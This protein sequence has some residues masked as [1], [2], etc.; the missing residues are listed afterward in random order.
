MFWSPLPF[1]R[2]KCHDSFF[3]FTGELRLAG[4][5]NAS[6]SPN[7]AVFGRLCKE[8]GGSYHRE[9]KTSKIALFLACR[10]DFCKCESDVGKRGLIG[11]RFKAGLASNRELF[12]GVGSSI[13]FRYVG[14]FKQVVY[15][16]IEVV[17]SYFFLTVQCFPLLCKTF[18]QMLILL[19][20]NGGN[21][22]TIV[23]EKLCDSE[24]GI[25]DEKAICSDPLHFD[26]DRIV[27]GICC[28]VFCGEG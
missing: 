6:I 18:F 9:A 26:A 25:T 11:A 15:G 2:H 14:S 17:M 24:R 1:K 5:S 27:C 13:H 4:S 10:V 16:D 20:T 7:K 28:T 3:R 12:R 22:D 23:L 8:N 21:V 19:L